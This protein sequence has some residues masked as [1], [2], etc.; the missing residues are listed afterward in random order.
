MDLRTTTST[1]TFS[2]PFELPGHDG[3]L[4]AG[5]YELVIEEEPLLGLSFEA[6]RRT[7]SYLLVRGQAEN[8]GATEMRLVDPKDVEAALGRDRKQL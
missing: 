4:P 5:T 7:A 8:R 2:H 1:V 6:Y 3:E